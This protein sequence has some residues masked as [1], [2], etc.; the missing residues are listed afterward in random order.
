M[1]AAR[2][3]CLDFPFVEMNSRA[4]YEKYCTEMDHKQA[5]QVSSSFLLCVNSYKH[6]DGADL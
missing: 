1:A 5:C 3:P 6:G 2:N 4:K